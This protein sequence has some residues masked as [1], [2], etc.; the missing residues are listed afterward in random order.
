[1]PGHDYV[2]PEGITSG[3]AEAKKYFQYVK[4]FSYLGNKFY[5]DINASSA[6]LNKLYHLVNMEATALEVETGTDLV[7]SWVNPSD[8]HKAIFLSTFCDINQDGDFEGDADF[9]YGE[10]GLYKQI[11]FGHLF[12]TVVIPIPADAP[13]GY[14]RVRMRFDSAWNEAY[15]AGKGYMPANASS[16]RHIYDIIIRVVNSYDPSGIEKPT[17]TTSQNNKVYSIYGAFLG[18]S[19]DGLPAGIYIVNGKKVVKR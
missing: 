10:R 12:G 7:I 1:M 5:G 13:T 14:T 2:I 18:D 4:S 16:N 11:A 8:M 6:E 15:D 17:Q 9:A 19:L 3:I